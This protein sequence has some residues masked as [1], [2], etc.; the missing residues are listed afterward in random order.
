MAGTTRPAPSRKTNRLSW[1]LVVGQ[2]V[3]VEP[4]V[5][6]L[7]GPLVIEPGLPDRRDDDPVARQ[8]DGVA[9]A[10]IDGRHLAA[11]EGPVER[12]FRPLALDGDDEPLLAGA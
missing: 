7:V 5:G 8:V 10:L 6:V 9:V 11:G 2:G 12:V 4:L 3:G 1:A